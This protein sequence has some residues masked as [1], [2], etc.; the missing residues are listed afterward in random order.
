M[1]DSSKIAR[2]ILKN[3]VGCGVCVDICPTHAIPYSLIGFFSSLAK[4]SEKKCKGC[5][6]CVQICPH[7]AIRM[8]IY[9]SSWK[10]VES[11]V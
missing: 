9:E 3:C 2:L 1:T 7:G 6:E 8:D 4:I 11:S 10:L 5:G